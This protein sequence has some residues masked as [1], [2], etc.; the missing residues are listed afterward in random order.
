MAEVKAVAEGKV[1]RQNAELE[2][3]I[4]FPG[5]G[6][7]PLGGFVLSQRHRGAR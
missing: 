5:Q 7:G 3:G 4:L 2:P 1:R 6:E